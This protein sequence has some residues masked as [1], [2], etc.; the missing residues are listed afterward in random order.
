[1]KPVLYIAGPMYGI[2]DLNIPAFNHLAA[3]AEERGWAVLNPAV[4]PMDMPHDH[5]MPIC[6][7]MLQQADCMYMLPGYEGHQGAAAEL[8]YAKSQ[9]IPV[10]YDL[11][12]L[13]YMYHALTFSEIEV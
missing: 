1:M 3:L 7:N 9:G 10:T 13:D 8:A 11:D 6:I 5:Y 2:E 12:E 4:L